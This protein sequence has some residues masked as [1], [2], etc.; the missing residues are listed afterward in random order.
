M[1]IHAIIFLYFI[2]ASLS[3]DT[4]YVG[5]WTGTATDPNHSVSPYKVDLFLWE[6]GQYSCHSLTHG[7]TCLY[8]GTDNESPSKVFKLD[9]QGNGQIDVLDATEQ[10]TFRGNLSEIRLSDEGVF[11]FKFSVHVRNSQHQSSMVYSLTKN[12]R[13]LGKNLKM[14]VD[15]CGMTDI[16]N[17]E[18][19]KCFH[20]DPMKVAIARNLTAMTIIHKHY[21]DKVL[22]DSNIKSIELST[23][24]PDWYKHPG[25]SRID[26]CIRVVSASAPKYSQGEFE[27]AVVI[28]GRAYGH[29]MPLHISVMIGIVPLFG[30][31]CIICSL[32]F[33]YK[34][35][36]QRIARRKI[37]VEQSQVNYYELPQ[38]VLLHSQ[39][40]VIPP[41]YVHF[42]HMQPEE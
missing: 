5:A 24:G 10:V 25:Y 12:P 9:S 41:P 32:I 36:S 33:A 34:I 8:W 31:L 38:D 3:L 28:H 19:E 11:S 29:R 13:Y 2:S 22:P 37:A 14:C 42:N 26:Y 23:F 30:V 4:K 1:K 20:Y 16:C 35:R 27:N 40:F 6:D 15:F 18:T 17:F 39:F 7:H 21:M